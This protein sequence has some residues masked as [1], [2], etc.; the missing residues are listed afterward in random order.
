[1]LATE[2]KLIATLLGYSFDSF[3][4]SP[5]FLS[6]KIRSVNSHAKVEEH[7]NNSVSFSFWRVWN[8]DTLLIFCFTAK[9]SS[10]YFSPLSVSFY[11]VSRPSLPSKLTFV[12]SWIEHS[13]QNSTSRR[14][15]SKD[16][17]V[18]QRFFTTKPEMNKVSKKEN[19]TWGKSEIIFSNDNDLLL[20]LSK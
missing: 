11:S 12:I 6:R 9:W 18:N 2:L 1:M 3:P 5:E 14:N 4:Q 10:I 19:F 20:R 7:S 8:W 15:G 13:K 16:Q 17:T